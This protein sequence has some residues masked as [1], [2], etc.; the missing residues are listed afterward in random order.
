MDCLG[1]VADQ[2]LPC[3]CRRKGFQYGMVVPNEIVDSE[4][5]VQHQ[6]ENDDGSKTATNLGSAERLDQEQKNQDRTGSPNNGGRRDALV[7]KPESLDRTEDRLSR[8]Q[9]AIYK[10]ASASGTKSIYRLH[11]TRDQR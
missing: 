9:D 4:G 1:F 11:G 5:E 8:G 2:V 7:H 10:A 6:P 3:E